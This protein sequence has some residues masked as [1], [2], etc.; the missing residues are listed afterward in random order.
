M[1]AKVAPFDPH[2]LAPVEAQDEHKIV[3]TRV[4][5]SGMFDFSNT[6]AMKQKVRKAKSNEKSAYNVHDFYHDTGFFQ[7]VARHPTFENVTLSVI[8]INALWISVD[9]DGN[10]A[11][12]IVKAKPVYIVADTLFFGYFLVELVTRFL[13]FKNK[14]N[15]FRDGW[16]V[17]DTALVTLYAFDPFVIGLIAAVSGG[18][19][20]DLPTAVL[21]L[22]RLARLSRLVRMLRSLPELMIMIKGMV[23]AAASVGYTLGLLVMITYVFSIAFR[24]LAPKPGAHHDEEED[25][26]IVFFSSVPETMHNLIIF[27]TFLDELASFAIPVKEQS[28]ACFCLMWVYI[29]IASLTVM[30]MLVGVLCEVIAAVAEEEKETM[31]VDKVNEKFNTIIADLDTDMDGSLSWDEFQKILDKPETHKALASVNV[32]AE[33]MVDIAEDYFF[34]NGEA[35]AV[36][37][38]EFMQLLLD[39]RGGQ[40]A[41]VK[42]LMTMGKGLSKKFNQTADRMDSLKGKMDKAMSAISDGRTAPSY[43]TK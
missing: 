24:N 40:Q 15:C 7:W 43:P 35:V 26:T 28:T 36:S 16:F 2:A 42:N 23:T 33:T 8:V 27:A 34:E 20:L 29:A 38:E 32:D 30:N 13:A 1:A 19:G 37:F 22:F 12:T 17:F 39:L 9:T 6:E 31:M 25:I 14:C 10:T 11:E 4:R 3:C 41:T 21:R 18:G 5:S